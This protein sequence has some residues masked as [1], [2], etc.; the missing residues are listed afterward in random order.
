MSRIG[1][2]PKVLHCLKEFVGLHEDERLYRMNDYGREQSLER[3]VD[4]W[5]TLNVR[6]CLGEWV[7]QVTQNFKSLQFIRNKEN[8][9]FLGGTG[10]GKSFLALPIG[11]CGSWH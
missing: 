6:L 5:R 10:V 9:V 4:S 2:R 11:H 7:N 1:V 8:M 3:P